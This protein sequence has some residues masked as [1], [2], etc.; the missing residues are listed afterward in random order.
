MKKIYLLV[1]VLAVISCQSEQL[2]PAVNCTTYNLEVVV[3]NVV[4]ATC[5][6]TDGQITVR[7]TGGT[8]DY[9][10]FL[11]G[12]EQGSAVFTNLAPGNYT[13]AVSDGNCSVN[14]TT[15]VNNTD[16]LS[17]ESVGIV[18]SGCGS[19]SGS[20]TLTTIDGVEPVVYSLDGSAPQESNVFVGLGQGSYEVVASDQTGCEVTQQ[21]F[22]PSGESYS[23][24][25]QAIIQNN[26][27]SASCHGGN[28]PPDFRQFSN[29]QSSAGRIKATTQS[30]SMPPNSS[31]TQSEI[32][33]IA[34][35]VDDGAL[36]N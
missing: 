3:E 4:D 10:Y 12:Q 14:T 22:V 36:D 9:Q 29:V 1:L 5:A 18:Q 6:N 26:C 19:S 17:V 7:A 31:L 32:D 15:A 8:G 20:I 28:Q 33:A 21:V 35:W 2:D 11:N 16:G 24:S 30:G 34:C 23:N 25:V 13:V 27:V